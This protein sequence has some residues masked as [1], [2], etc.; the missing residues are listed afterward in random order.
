MELLREE[1]NRINVFTDA[2]IKKQLKMFCASTF[3][4]LQCSGTH[5]G[6]AEIFDIWIKLGGIQ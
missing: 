6:T 2:H 5:N 1:E 3:K 4:F